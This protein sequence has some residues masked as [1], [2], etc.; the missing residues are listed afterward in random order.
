MLTF[1][2]ADAHRRIG[3]SFGSCDIGGDREPTDPPLRTGRPTG[4]YS[5]SFRTV[6]LNL[7]TN[8]VVQLAPRMFQRDDTK[9][10]ERYGKIKLELPRSFEPFDLARWYMG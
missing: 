3:G 4:M 6:T 9:A 1:L 7:R 2:V 8:E 5:E 10:R